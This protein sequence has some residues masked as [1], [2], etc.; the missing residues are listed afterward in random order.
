MAEVV[1][2][3]VILVAETPAAILVKEDE[4]ADEIWLPKSQIE[5]DGEIGETGAVTLPEWLA[6]ER[7]LA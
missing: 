3:E 5:I 2:I 7:G 1:D 4:E 6:I